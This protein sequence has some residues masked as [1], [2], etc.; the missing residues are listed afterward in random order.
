MLPSCFGF[1]RNACCIWPV[2]YTSV[3]LLPNSA[4][5][6]TQ[7]DA[8]RKTISTPVRAYGQH[9]MSHHKAADLVVRCRWARKNPKAHPESAQKTDTAVD[10]WQQTIYSDTTRKSLAMVDE[11]L[12]NYDLLEALVVHIVQEQS[13]CGPAAMLQVRNKNMQSR[14]SHLFW[15]SARR[16]GFVQL[17]RKKAVCQSKKLLGV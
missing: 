17:C 16:V 9:A 6:D 7:L 12:L 3:T 13:A 11:G 5:C 4:Q 10:D 1:T 15:A 2:V 8:C 14:C